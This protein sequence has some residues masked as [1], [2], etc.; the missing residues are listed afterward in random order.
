[1]LAPT[2]GDLVSGLLPWLANSPD[3]SL[4]KHEPVPPPRASPPP[5]QPKPPPPQ[6]KTPKVDPYT[7]LP[8]PPRGGEPSA[9]YR[10]FPPVT[11]G[12]LTI[13]SQLAGHRSYTLRARRLP[14][15]LATPDVMIYPHSEETSVPEIYDDE[16]AAKTD[17][18]EIAPHCYG[19]VYDKNK[20]HLHI[21]TSHPHYHETA[22]LESDVTFKF[23]S[24]TGIERDDA[25]KYFRLLPGVHAVPRAEKWWYI[26]KG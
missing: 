1:M 18:V 6:Q 19:I 9:L 22:T 26:M 24:S 13:Q 7:G 8:H 10:P 2:V 17:S 15:S 20:N 3:A 11:K 5:K 4:P 23:S 21:F 12:A 25:S 16:F 14:H